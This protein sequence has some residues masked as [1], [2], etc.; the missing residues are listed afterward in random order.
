M[1]SP[2]HKDNIMQ[3]DFA[4]ALAHQ[5]KYKWEYNCEIVIS[6]LASLSTAKTRF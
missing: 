6:Y 3:V 1:D 2:P 5:I 4:I